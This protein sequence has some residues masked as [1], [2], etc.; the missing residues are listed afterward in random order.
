MSDEFYRPRPPEQAEDGPGRLGLFQLSASF[1]AER[2]RWSLWLPVFL[3]AGIGIYFSLPMEPPALLGAL[4]TLAAL[5]LGLAGRKNQHF[6]LAGFALGAM[7]LG[8]VAAQWRTYSLDHTVLAAKHGPARLSGRIARIETFPNGNRV[9]LDRP[10][11]ARLPADQVPERVRVRLRGSQP[12]LAP[13]DWI[14]MR[15]VLSPPSA[16]TS[17]GAF[18][19]QRRAY[20][21][22]LGAVGFAYGRARLVA[23]ASGSGGWRE[24]LEKLRLAISLRVRGAID[25]PAGAVAAALMTGNRAAIPEDVMRAFR[26]SG[27]A[28]LLAISGLHIGLFAGVL[29]FGVRALLALVPPLALRFPIKKWAALVAIIGAFAYALIAGATVPTQRAFV[30][31]G[32]VLVA[33]LLDRQG[34]SMRLVAWAASVILAF[35]PESLLGPSFQMSFAAVVALIAGWEFYTRH[36]ARREGPPPWW[37]RPPAFLAGVA[38]TTLIA[39]SATAPFAIYHFN[40]FAVYALAANLIAV[41][42][43]SLLIMPAAVI[44]FFLMPLGLDYLALV[45]MGWGVE[46]VLSVA[47][48]VAG[49]PGSVILVPAAPAFGVIL[50]AAGGLWLCLWRLRWRF[51]GLAV[52]ALGLGVFSLGQKPDILV[53]GEGR[54]FAVKGGGGAYILS[55][56]RRARFSGESWLRRV[57][58]SLEAAPAWPKGAGEG[59]LACDNLGCIYRRGDYRVALITDPLALIEDCRRADLVI[60]AVPVRGPCPSAQ[61]VIDRFDLWREGAH[62]I[63]LDPAGPRI[64]SV[65]QTRGDRPW[66]IKPRRRARR[67]VP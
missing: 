57:G 66:V 5:G 61:R 24:G 18:D 40:R 58:Q 35:K 22:Q 41:P 63:W 16:P 62:A 29:F 67:A 48:T 55:S 37:W 44:A 10:V 52:I 17:P 47:R 6:Q 50:V 53:D 25:G 4:I 9:T 14:E 15:A 2:E 23:P 28:H 36:R 19:F 8:L 64:Q 49:W 42:I 26:D 12:A 45:P 39:S 21:D 32:L 33:V 30:M 1:L 51:L 3:G 31:V 43:T 60:S 56:K 59:P 65:A 7:A 11:I 54:L 13:G 38:L 27:L 46:G 34:L 20:F